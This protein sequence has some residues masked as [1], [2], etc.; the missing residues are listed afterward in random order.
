M[1]PTQMH[2]LF[3]SQIGKNIDNTN[4][5]SYK[6]I[7]ALWSSYGCDILAVVNEIVMEQIFKDKRITCCRLR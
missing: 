2:E 4:D 1:S 7:F 5:F 6:Y 3:A